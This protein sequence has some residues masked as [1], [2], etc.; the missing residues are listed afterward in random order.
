MVTPIKKKEKFSNR[1][2]QNLQTLMAF[3]A[4]NSTL[5]I[6]ISAGKTAKR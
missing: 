4:N 2:S 3:P 1:D 5:L 6:N